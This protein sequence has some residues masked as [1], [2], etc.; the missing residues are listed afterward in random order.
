MAGTDFFTTVPPSAFCCHWFFL[1]IFSFFLAFSSLSSLFRAVYILTLFCQKYNRQI[2]QLFIL[3]FDNGN[4]SLYTE[5]WVEA[6]PKAR[7]AQA[8][9]RSV[10]W[11]RTKG[12]AGSGRCPKQRMKPL[13]ERTL[14]GR[15]TENDEEK[16]NPL[17]RSGW[18]TA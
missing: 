8:D 5:A 6:G 12:K 2:A 16:R 14:R 7:L 1:R 17:F 4:I 3:F 10:G 9:A 13:P 18:D 11:S 15:E